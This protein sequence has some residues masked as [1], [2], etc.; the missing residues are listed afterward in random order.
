M[1]KDSSYIILYKLKKIHTL[2]NFLRIELNTIYKK[3]GAPWVTV[4]KNSSLFSQE[5]QQLQRGHCEETSLQAAL[6]RARIQILL[7]M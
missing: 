1:N 3:N 5:A 2:N 6:G 7:A 4:L